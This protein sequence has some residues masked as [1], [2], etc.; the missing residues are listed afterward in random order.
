M[1][2]GIAVFLEFRCHLAVIVSALQQAAKSK[3]T[4]QLLWSVVSFEYGFDLIEKGLGD[5][6][7]V[8]SSK[9]LALSVEVADI[10]RVFQNPH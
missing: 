8:R 9:K 2:V 7:C 5:K 1:I 3:P 6:R 10:E 4:F